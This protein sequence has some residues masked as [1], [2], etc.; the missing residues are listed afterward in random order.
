VSFAGHDWRRQAAAFLSGE[1]PTFGTV[2]VGILLK[3]YGVDALN[4]D[5]LTVRVQIGEDF[6]TDVARVPYGKMMSLINVMT[7]DTVYYSVPVFD[8]TVHGLRGSP[9]TQMEEIPEADDV[10][11]AVAEIVMADPEPPKRPGQMTP[12]SPDIAGYVGLVLDHEGISGEPG[13]LSWARRRNSSA[14]L[15]TNFSTDPD[16]FNAAQGPRQAKA[17]EVD[18]VVK[19]RVSELIR[20]LS[21]LGVE[22]ARLR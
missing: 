9:G 13:V 12:W 21:S 15:A 17:A 7:T 16:F 19:S 18:E 11:T 20:Q 6:G 8:A 10:A 22:P 14:P 2:L 1:T 4:W 5:P 3:A